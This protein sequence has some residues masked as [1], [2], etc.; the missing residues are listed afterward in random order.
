MSEKKAVV[1]LSG[2]LDSTTVAALARS[3]GYTLLALSFDYGQR[4]RRE[5][6]AARAV[7]AHL[8]CERWLVVPLV[9]SQWGGSALTADID[10]PKGRSMDEMQSAIPVTYVPARNT[11]FIAYGLAYAEA[12]DADA[13][14]IG[15]SAVDYSGYPDCRPEYVAKYQELMDLATKK[16]VEGGRIVLEAPLS[17]LSKSEIICLGL[18]LNAPYHLTWSCYEGGEQ[19]CGEC[20]SCQLRLRGFAKAGIQDPIAYAPPK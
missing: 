17:G 15:V 4:H 18:K 13:I 3:Q 1:L 6:E 16:T 2:G 19:A 11:L 8:R 7:A 20:D 12:S 10:V 9:L 14:F 5:L